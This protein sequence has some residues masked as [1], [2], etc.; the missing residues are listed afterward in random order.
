M[1]ARVPHAWEG[2]DHLPAGGPIVVIANHYQRP[3]LWIGWAGALIT[4]G[5]ARQTGQTLCWLTLGDLVVS[6]GGHPLPF[7]GAAWAFERVN[8]AWGL[9]P[10]TD[11][12]SPQRRAEALRAALGI[13]RKG[14]VLGLF[15]EGSGGSAS[16]F[17]PFL[18]GTE[19][20]LALAARTGAAVV[21]VG[22]REEHRRL[23]ARFG[24]PVA[25]DLGGDA[26]ASN[27]A[28][29]AVAR[30]LP[31]ADPTGATRP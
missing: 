14:G 25:F 9:I 30:L 4:V 23:V 28:H 27:L 12:P 29:Q 3:D 31:S 17:G 5:V 24:P 15:P 7:P 13:V 2:L 26:E 6:V 19:R 10:I 11:W 1:L 21:P 20:F 16:A 8:A 22:V 18:P